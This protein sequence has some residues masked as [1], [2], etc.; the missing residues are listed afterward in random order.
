METGNQI[1]GII[2]AKFNKEDGTFEEKIIENITPLEQAFDRAL[3]FSR[4]LDDAV[5]LVK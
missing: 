4:D 3:R 2:V 5:K 1:D